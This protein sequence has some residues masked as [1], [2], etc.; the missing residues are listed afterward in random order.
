M[1]KLV[2]RPSP[3]E[4]VHIPPASASPFMVWSF[5]VIGP[6][7]W[8]AFRLLAPHL[9]RLSRGSDHSLNETDESA[10]KAGVRRWVYP[11]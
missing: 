3:R 8:R 5:S 10:D 11:L 9:R 4:Y 7:E 2:A 6:V 1:A